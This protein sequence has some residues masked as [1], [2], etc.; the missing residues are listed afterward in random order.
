MPPKNILKYI[1]DIESV[2]RELELVI[3][4]HE[5]DYSKFSSNFMAVRTVERDLEIIGEAVRK[6]TLLDPTIVIS[7]SK[8]IIGLRNMIVHAY[9]S[10]DPTTLWKI[11]IKDLPILKEDIVKIKNM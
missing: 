7:C 9:D 6:I 10:I 2:I 1:L 3:E 8:H 4:I 11:L 5:I